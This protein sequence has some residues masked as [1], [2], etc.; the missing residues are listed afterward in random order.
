MILILASFARC[1]LLKK[2]AEGF[3]YCTMLGIL[4]LAVEPETNSSDITK[5]VQKHWDGLLS[6]LCDRVLFRVLSLTV[7]RLW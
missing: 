5:H 6:T 2:K 1:T 3:P 4:S 7:L